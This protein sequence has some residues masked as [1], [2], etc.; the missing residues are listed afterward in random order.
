MEKI[1]NIFEKTA[2]LLK[3]NE[4]TLDVLTPQ[5]VEDIN[6]MTKSHTDNSVTNLYEQ[7]EPEFDEF[8]DEELEKRR[9]Y[10]DF[11]DEEKREIDQEHV[12]MTPFKPME[13]KILKTLHKNLD[14]SELQKLSTDTPEAYGGLD[15]KFWDI[16]KLFGISVGT[17]EENTRISRYTKW[18]LDN[19]TEDGDYGNIENPIKVPLKWYGVDREESGSQVEYKSGDA[20]VL[21]FD[22]DDAGDRADYDFY[23]WG[24]EMETV[25]YGDYETYDTEITNTEFIRMDETKQLKESETDL[26]TKALIA[27]GGIQR[28][29]VTTPVFIK[30]IFNS[31]NHQAGSGGKEP[32]DGKKWDT[33]YTP[34]TNINLDQDVQRTRDRIRFE[35]YGQMFQQGI[36][37]RG[38]AFEGMLA[39]LFDGE[40]MKAGGK[41]DIK[42]GSDY[43][44]IKQSNPGDAWD[45]GSL[46][47]GYKFAKENMVNDGFSEEEIPPTP[48]DLMVA[49]NNYTQY[50]A[51]M[52]IE[53]FKATN[54]QPLQWIFAH[55]L[56]DKQIQYDVLSSEDLISTI[57]SSDCS[58]GTGSRACAVGQS[59]K[60]DTGLRVKSRFVLG[61]DP[62]IITFP[63]VNEEDIRSI[64]YDP[65]GD[66]V[67]D[68]IR[69]IFKDPN[70][71]SQY[72]VDYI[73]NNP[74]E[75]LTSVNSIL[76]NLTNEQKK[77]AYNLLVEQS[78]IFGQGLSDPIEPEDFDGEEEEWEELVDNVED[79]K[80]EDEL[81]IYTGG[82]TDP[83]KGF[84]APSKEVTNNIC[85]V[86]G[87]C[88]EQG[89]ITFGQLKALVEKATTQRIKA[90]I[91]RGVFKSLWRLVP[92]F[93]PQIL[94]AAVGVTATRA[95]NKIITPALKDT[96]GYKSWWGKAVLKAMDVA[97]GDYI[98]DVALG[99][100]PLSKV[101]FISDGL[102]SMIKDK[103]KLKFA[104]YV[105][106]VA[107]NEPDNKP[108]PEWF[109]ENLLRDYLN[110]KFLLSPPL[111]VKYNIDTKEQIEESKNPFGLLSDDWKEQ[112]INHEAQ[113][114]DNELKYKK[115]T[116]QI[117][118]MTVTMPAVNLFPTIKIPTEI[119]FTVI[120]PYA[121]QGL[122]PGFLS[123]YDDDYVEPGK[124]PTVIKYDLVFMG[125]EPGL[126][127]LPYDGGTISEIYDLLGDY[128]HSINGYIMAK[129]FKLY[130]ID[131]GRLGHIYDVVDGEETT[132]KTLKEQDVMYEW[133]NPGEV[134]PFSKETHNDTK[135][136][137]SPE[138][139]YKYLDTTHRE[140]LIK[141]LRPVLDCIVYNCYGGW[142][143]DPENE[144]PDNTDWMAEEYCGECHDEFNDNLENLDKDIVK[145]GFAL[146]HNGEEYDDKHKKTWLEKPFPYSYSLWIDGVVKEINP[147]FYINSEDDVDY[148]IKEINQYIHQSIV[149][150]DI[151]YESGEFDK[152]FT[153]QEHSDIL[154]NYWSKFGPTMEKNTM[155]LLGFDTHDEGDFRVVWDNLQQYY[156]DEELN[157]IILERLEGLHDSWDYEYIV[158]TMYP[159]EGYDCVV[160]IMVNGDTIIPFSTEEGITEMAL[161]EINEESER[162]GNKGYNFY[163]DTVEKV[164]DDI[165]LD[166]EE[167]LFK[168]LP[169]DMVLEYMEVSGPGEFE[170]YV[171]SGNVE[172]ITEQIHQQSQD[173]EVGDRIMA[174][175]ISGMQ[176]ISGED[177]YEEGIPSTFIATVVE[178]LE[179]DQAKENGMKYMV[180]ID[181]AD[182]IVGLY[183]GE[184]LGGSI[185]PIRNMYQKGT[186][187]KW[188]KL[189]K[190]EDEKVGQLHE[191]DGYIDDMVYRDEPRD[192]HTRRMN[193]DL[194]DLKGF[195]LERYMNMPPPENESDKTEEEIGYL[196]EIPVDKNL[197]DSADEIRKHFNGFLTPKGL[198]YPKEE[199]KEVMVG[200]KAIILK[201]KY[202][203][204]RPRPWQIAQAKG[205]KLNSE[206][207]KSSSS[208][209]YPSGHATQGRFI[210][211][212]LSELYPEYAQQLTQIGDDIAF[213]R[214]MAK[215]HYPSDS[216]FGKL[217]ADDMYDYVYNKETEPELQEQYD[218][219]TPL[220]YKK[221][222]TTGQ[223]F[224][225]LDDNFAIEPHPKGE[226]TYDGQQMALYSHI[227]NKFVPI[228]ELY[229][230]I[231]GMNEAGL[232]KDDVQIVIEIV[233]EWVN[234]RMFVKPELY[235]SLV[236]TTKENISPDLKIGDRIYVWD[237]E[238]DD[239]YTTLPS[240]AVAVVVDGPFEGQDIT[241]EVEDEIS[242]EHFGL[243]GKDEA[244]NYYKDKW[245]ILPPKPLREGKR[246]PIQKVRLKRGVSDDAGRSVVYDI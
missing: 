172:V 50:Q 201:L 57:L 160:E 196:E 39:G 40:P 49:G 67:E 75:F 153:R 176:S 64:I 105:S 58:K 187:D 230:A 92:F 74:E 246:I 216:G 120:R 125:L 236:D 36:E 218:R 44:S 143:N 37:G 217:L 22:E 132:P 20:E 194:G 111:P 184:W 144:N 48:V 193:R 245:V 97:E 66:R 14:R 211:R 121:F 31:S 227:E 233:T 4:L 6:G 226:I 72:T 46:Q 177:F 161:W 90:D 203:Y 147:R 209:S 63:T 77:L 9:T 102:M 108:V 113:L 239:M 175:D 182:E 200:V 62:K 138:T 238:I 157:N 83:E 101:F 81:E 164:E 21:G 88:Q 84:V 241:Y 61:T 18:A 115:L 128:N 30:N 1:K 69:R 56:N 163:E 170:E 93:I 186:R 123:T 55:V 42:V 207:L 165:R 106:E 3:E 141:D 27:I 70:K 133:D 29:K 32:E 243:Y 80:Y 73:K 214:N 8:S 86:E 114:S 117:D 188:L 131:E 107:S 149:K 26:R 237:V 156:G 52:L 16:M 41:E 124:E 152:I 191:D 94:L 11:S 151:K 51:Q 134:K 205:L 204:N 231:D 118:G 169:V 140:K 12:D 103:Y 166:M 179:Y 208:P 35:E 7:E 192:K 181:N 139:L 127:V 45:T 87:F 185:Y 173:L 25:D 17:T 224:K 190:G 137:V 180:K 95:I 202:H 112:I 229:D 104:R 142:E 34:G 122:R 219:M 99:D 126:D 24:G 129:Y 150:E 71:V 213:S 183:G 68:K 235:E 10:D 162:F 148:H 244:E 210:G 79:D 96:G 199:L 59:R 119:T 167:V 197:V 171:K 130:G 234:S 212:Y 89:P 154:F 135:L 100:D 54:G 47:T 146:E 82:K 198:E 221:L 60:S 206:T 174:W 33:F 19:W 85:N 38:F 2:Q 222:D 195:P 98:P 189:P 116:D 168:D 136:T 28:D 65:E 13:V 178:V 232:H 145:L 5:I 91:G 225:I 76:P 223:L 15:K 23:A 228:A 109:V 155:K 220:E 158:T 242:G 53:S 110:Q 43:Y 78:D 159:Y 240:N 215:V